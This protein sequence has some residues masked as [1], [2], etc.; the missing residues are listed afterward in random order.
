MKMADLDINSII[1]SLSPEDM[2]NIRNLAS[3]FLGNNSSSETVPEKKAVTDNLPDLSKLSGMGMPDLSQ[4]SAIVPVLQM[5]NKPDSR[6]E[7]INALKPLLSESRRR[8]A[9]EAMNL[10]RLISVIPVLRERGML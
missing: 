10:L 1:N 2:A 5:F 7:F 6:V 9:D 8:K 3:E 4:L